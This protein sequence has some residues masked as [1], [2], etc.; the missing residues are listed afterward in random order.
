M[1]TEKDADL[2]DL[3][4]PS[5]LRIQ[6]VAYNA[7]SYEIEDPITYKNDVSEF[8]HPHQESSISD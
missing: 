1:T 2:I 8:P 4:L 5:G 3:K 7:K 6:Q